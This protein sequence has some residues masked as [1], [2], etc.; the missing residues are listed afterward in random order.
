[1][2]SRAI[3][4]QSCPHLVPEPPVAYAAPV[5]E[6]PPAAP[7]RRRLKRPGLVVIS[8]IVGLIVVVLVATGAFAERDDMIVGVPAGTPMDAGPFTVTI[9]GVAST[10]SMIADVGDDGTLT[11]IPNGWEVEVYGTIE[12]HLTSTYKLTEGHFLGGESGLRPLTW[13]VGASEHDLAPGLPPQPFTLNFTL[14]AGEPFDPDVPFP[15]GVNVQMEREVDPLFASGET[16]WVPAPR[17]LRTE[18][19]P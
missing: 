10:Q 5:N 1:M 15:V 4:A 18:I 7:G 16:E 19:G 3:S 6:T 11:D 8:A 17:V 2:R 14:P 13:T 9:T 12:S